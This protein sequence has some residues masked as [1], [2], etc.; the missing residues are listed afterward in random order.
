MNHT[1]VPYEVQYR[2]LIKQVLSQG[3]SCDAERTG[4]GSRMLT[5]LSMRVDLAKEF[6]ILTSKKV[7]FDKIVE[8]DLW[9]IS[10]ST[11]NDDL[12]ARGVKFWTDWESEAGQLGPVYGAMW[13]RRPASLI[14]YQEMV[15]YQSTSVNLTKVTKNYVKTK[16]RK[17]IS[18]EGVSS[19]G[20]AR[21]IT[22]VHKVWYD[23]MAAAALAGASVYAPWTDPEGFRKD[24]AKIPGNE[25]LSLTFDFCL[26]VPPK[27]LVC[28]VTK[29]C[30]VFAPDTMA[31]VSDYLA[32]AY[33]AIPLKDRENVLIPVFYI[34]QLQECIDDVMEHSQSR[35]II[36]DSWDPSLAAFQ[37]LPPNMQADHG[38]QA[39][40]PCHCFFQFN[41]RPGKG[42][43]K[44][45]LD[46]TLYMRS[47]DM[48][49]GLPFNMVN[50][51]LLT[52]MV[53]SMAGLQ[54]GVLSWT[55]GNCHIYANHVSQ[56]ETQLRRKV[57]EPVQIEP[58]PSRTLIGDYVASDFKLINYRPAAAIKGKVAV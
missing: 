43:E 23:M 40:P 41:V 29:N 24:F 54:P 37:N 4:T 56:L 10:G 17:T 16:C 36:V 49:L 14:S 44:S 18:L 6:P 57:R 34:D 8:E 32:Q 45:F 1:Y 22:A 47:S 26:A 33:P 38:R 39:L 25:L 3:A 21:H 5:G 28:V 12:L 48:F 58:V 19:S 46:L 55:G 35:R 2:N 15:P 20:V 11:S 27:K 31:I 42:G 51:A 50:Y 53:A 7:N 30:N 9:F 52:H 13:R